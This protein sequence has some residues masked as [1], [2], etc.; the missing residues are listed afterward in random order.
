MSR[1]NKIV[2]AVCNGSSSRVADD[3]ISDRFFFFSFFPPPLLCDPGS[4]FPWLLSLSHLHIWLDTT[5]KSISKVPSFYIF[6][7]SP[8]FVYLSVITFLLNSAYTRVCA[9]LPFHHAGHQITFLI[10]CWRGWMCPCERISDKEKGAMK[11]W[12]WC[13]L[14]DD[15]LRSPPSRRPD[16]E[17]C[18]PWLAQQPSLLKPR[19][20]CASGVTRAPGGH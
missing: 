13:A 17:Q 6:F 18:S 9:S 4:P 3:G 16:S 12:E 2:S 15:V 8:P 7:F 1:R 14:D 19:D 11:W 20:R 10:T 5:R